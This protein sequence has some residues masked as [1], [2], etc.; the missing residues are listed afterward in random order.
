[1]SIISAAISGVSSIVGGM[2]AASAQKKAAR[3][4]AQQFAQTKEMIQPYTKAGE[5]ALGVYGN[6]IGLNGAAPQQEYFDN[7]INDPGY[8]KQLAAGVEA[9]GRSSVARGTA[10]GGNTLAAISDYSGNMLGNAYKTRL[11]QI[12]GV[13]D[14]GRQAAGTLAGA[15]QSYANAAGGNLANAGMLQGAGIQNAGNA[16]AGGLMNYAQNQNYQTALTGGSNYY[17]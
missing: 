4:Q 14:T 7:F 9:V 3:L 15:S 6:A 13:V 5:G 17:S 16:A 8:Q 12:G 10:Y 2:Q 11:S 1:M